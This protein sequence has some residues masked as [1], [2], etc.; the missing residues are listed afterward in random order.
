MGSSTCL[1]GSPNSV[2]C[3]SV[4]MASDKEEWKSET[5]CWN[6]WSREP[7]WWICSIVQTWKRWTA[8]AHGASDNW[9]TKSTVEVL[10]FLVQK[11]WA[12]L[13]GPRSSGVEGDRC[14]GQKAIWRHPARKHV[15][16]PSCWQWK[17]PTFKIPCPSRSSM[18][19]STSGRSCTSGHDCWQAIGSC[20][21]WRVRR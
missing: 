9:P 16:Q 21:S 13:R 7:N 15:K 1:K 5:L 12:T 20:P 4:R 17:A 18:L 3:S 2:R 10:K 19:N 8:L 6:K 14:H 11:K